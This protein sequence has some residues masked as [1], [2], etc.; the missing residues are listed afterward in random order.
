MTKPLT[1]LLTAA[2]LVAF[3]GTALA[4]RVSAQEATRAAD[5]LADRVE[6]FS[7]MAQQTPRY[8]RLG[9]EA[10]RVSQ[11]ATQIRRVVE[12][13]APLMQVMNQYRQLDRDFQQLRSDFVRTY[14]MQPNPQLRRA[15]FNVVLAHEALTLALGV[16]PQRLGPER[17]RQQPHERDWQ[18][19]DEPGFR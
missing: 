14:R 15:W 10:Q 1:A 2:L 3:A 17:P 13:R 6:Q 11:D 7:E 5:Q 12:R 9:R 18:E 16:D 8:Q 19:W 4:Q